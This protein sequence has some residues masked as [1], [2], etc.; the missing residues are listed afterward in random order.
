MPNDEMRVQKNRLEIAGLVRD[1]FQKGGN[2]IN[3]PLL[4]KRIAQLFSFRDLFTNAQRNAPQF[5]REEKNPE[6]RLTRE[7]VG[8]ENENYHLTFFALAPGFRGKAHSHSHVNCTSVV[9]HGP[10]TEVLYT[11]GN[12][13]ILSVSSVE[14]RQ[15][16]SVNADLAS[17][18]NT[19]I[20]SVGNYS[21]ETVYSLHVYGIHK[22]QAF[23]CYYDRLDADANYTLTISPVRPNF[24]ANFGLWKKYHDIELLRLK[25]NNQTESA[26]PKIYHTA[27]SLA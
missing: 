25:Q 5:M 19:F 9:L 26:Q 17:F 1:Y 14:C 27:V 11:Q 22:D 16:G 8:F 15:Q 18:V 21:A 2:W 7:A 6:K 3:L 12:Q 23:N 10:F 13:N 24:L 20:H 4:L